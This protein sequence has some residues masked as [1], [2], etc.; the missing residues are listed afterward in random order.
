MQVTE[1]INDGYGGMLGQFLHVRVLKDACQN[2]GIEATEDER[3]VLHTFVD[4]QLNVRGPQKER[5]SPQQPHARLGR[6]TRSR[7]TL[8]K[9]HGH[10]LSHQRLAR[11]GRIHTRIPPIRRLELLGQIQQPPQLRITVHHRDQ[12]NIKNDVNIAKPW[13]NTHTQP[14]NK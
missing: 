7:R 12:D 1:G 4:A 11:L 8:L 10:T 9:N 5:L 2:D 13:T 6:H 14:W 3:R